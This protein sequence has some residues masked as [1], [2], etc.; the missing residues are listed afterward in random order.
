MRG[1]VPLFTH[2][3]RGNTPRQCVRWRARTHEHLAYY[4]AWDGELSRVNLRQPHWTIGTVMQGFHQLLRGGNGIVEGCSTGEKPRRMH[5]VRIA[6]AQ[7]TQ[8]VL[9]TQRFGALVLRTA[10]LA[11]ADFQNMHPRHLSK[12]AFYHAPKDRF[13]EGVGRHSHCSQVLQLGYDAPAIVH[14]LGKIEAF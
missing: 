1:L 13:S 10:I 3:T 12:I 7:S 6:A 2:S 5:I 8:G 4:G 14:A 9:G 11:I